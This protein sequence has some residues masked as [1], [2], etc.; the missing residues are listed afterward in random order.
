MKRDKINENKQK[1]EK[2]VK[3]YSVKFRSKTNDG[4]KLVAKYKMI[5]CCKMQDWRRQCEKNQKKQ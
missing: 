4:L 2:D 3:E 1:S 5:D